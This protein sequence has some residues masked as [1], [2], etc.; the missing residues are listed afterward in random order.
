MKIKKKQQNVI[1]YNTAPN[2]STMFVLLQHNEVVANILMTYVHYATA[3]AHS[4][5]K[6]HKHLQSH[7]KRTT[8]VSIVAKL[9][10]AQKTMIAA[11]RAASKSRRNA[12]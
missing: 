9:Y 11:I 10:N 1:C 12:V 3:S 2:Q 5:N 6:C 8:Y 4:Q 7:V